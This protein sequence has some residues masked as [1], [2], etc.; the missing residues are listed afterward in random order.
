M[1]QRRR[2]RPKKLLPAYLVGLTDGEGCFYVNFRPSRAKIKRQPKV[3]LHFYLK[4]RGD[5]LLLLEKVKKAFGCG[6]I[7]H[8][9]EKRENHSECYRFEINSRNDIK[10]FLLPFFDQN[11]LQGSKLKD[12]KIF[13][14][15]ATIVFSQKLNAKNLVKIK[16]LKSEMNLGVRRVWKIRLLGGNV[17][18]R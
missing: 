4:L 13:K 6:A 3:E 1:T 17:K 7:Y 10:N 12:Y 8:Q 5:H 16:R 11:P 15:I 14:K 18:E 2:D 9:K